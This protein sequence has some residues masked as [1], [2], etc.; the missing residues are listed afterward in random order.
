MATAKAC[1][2]TD[3]KTTSANGT[4][5]ILA[6]INDPT[7]ATI[8]PASAIIPRVSE[9]MM[10]MTMTAAANKSATGKLLTGYLTGNAMYT[11]FV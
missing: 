4:A 8:A 10:Q 2:S 11:Q 7:H 5:S 6:A 1:G 9:I 3:L